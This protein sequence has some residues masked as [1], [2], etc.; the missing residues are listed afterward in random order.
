MQ[1]WSVLQ[2]WMLRD[3]AVANC[4]NLDGVKLLLNGLVLDYL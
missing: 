3:E 2:S 1:R 4:G